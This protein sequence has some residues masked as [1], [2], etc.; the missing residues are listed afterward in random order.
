MNVQKAF[1]DGQEAGFDALEALGKKYD[2]KNEEAMPSVYAGLLCTVM[3][4]MFAHAPSEESADEIIAW[5]RQT[6]EKDWQ[7]EQAKGEKR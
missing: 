4:C 6:A 2:G 1:Q 3:H 7:D 5:A